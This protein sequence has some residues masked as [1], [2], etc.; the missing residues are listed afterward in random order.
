MSGDVRTATLR[1]VIVGAGGQGKIVA[2]ILRAAESLGAMRAVGFVDDG[3]WPD[4]AQVMHLPVLGRVDALPGIEH[5]AVVVAVGDNR[6][7][8]TLSLALEARGELIV[9]VQHP[10]ASISADVE[11]G[12]GCM[13][14]AGAVI[15]PCVRLGRGVLVNTNASLDHDSVVGDFAH[16]GPRAVA[17][18]RVTI[19]TRVLV[20]LGASVMSGCCVGDDAVV[21]AGAVVTRDVADGAVV[22]GVP[23]RAHRPQ[24]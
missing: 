1:V 6:V 17:G 12:P 15:T 8:Q 11:L 7:R 2:D 19:G 9:S 21:G 10:S 23:A 13:I 3:A 22:V 20:G 18:G 24:G 16:V 4:V 5:D 14:S